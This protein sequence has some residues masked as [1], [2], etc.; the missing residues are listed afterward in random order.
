MKSAERAESLF[1]VL[2]GNASDHFV[3]AVLL[4]TMTLPSTPL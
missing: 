1:L 4:V 3:S 2:H